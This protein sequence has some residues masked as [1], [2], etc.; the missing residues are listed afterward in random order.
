MVD[1]ARKR[2]LDARMM[3]AYQLSFND[4]FHAVFSNA[5]LHWMKVDADLVIQGVRRALKTGG[6]FAAEMGGHGCVA[7]IVVALCATLEKR[8]FAQP[9]SF[10]PWHF[11]TVDDYSSLLARAGF[12]TEYISLNPRTTPMP[13]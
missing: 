3:D 12:H 8:G 9:A 6:R 2:G 10:I 7:A 1:A 4:E 5:V 13:T 11:P